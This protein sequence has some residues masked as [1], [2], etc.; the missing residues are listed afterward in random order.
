MLVTL[1]NCWN[2]VSGG[3]TYYRARQN[4]FGGLRVGF[5]RP[6]QLSSKGKDRVWIKGGE[7]YHKWAGPKTFRRPPLA[8]L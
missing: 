2:F 5:V 6:A 8:A 3:E 4:H 1:E 7:T